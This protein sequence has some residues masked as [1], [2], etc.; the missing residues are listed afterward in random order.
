MATKFQTKN[1]KR[2][3]PRNSKIDKAVTKIRLVLLTTKNIL[4]FKR[5][6]LVFG[7]MVIRSLGHAENC[8]TVLLGNWSFGPQILASRVISTLSLT[9]IPNL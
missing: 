3:H 9:N 8:A 6:F 2:Q 7:H 4:D 5:G 1:K